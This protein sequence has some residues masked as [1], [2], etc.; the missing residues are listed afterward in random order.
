[1][2]WRYVS[3]T[4]LFIFSGAFVSSAVQQGTRQMA[5]FLGFVSPEARTES[6][7]KIYRENVAFMESLGVDPEVVL[8]PPP[9]PVA[10]PAR[11]ARGRRIGIAPLR[12]LRSATTRLAGGAGAAAFWI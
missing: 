4:E 3:N 7:A 1:M 6:K 10:A 2:C 9:E 12:G 8:G 11:A 5:Y